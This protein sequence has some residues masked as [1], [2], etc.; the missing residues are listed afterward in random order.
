MA[1]LILEPTPQAQWQALVQEAPSVCDRHLD[2]SLES[3]LVF[4]LMRF[5]DQPQ[6]VARSMAED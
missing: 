1:Q 6:C 2:E 3:S 5:A 4:M